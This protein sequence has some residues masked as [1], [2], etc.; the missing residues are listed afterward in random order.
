MQLPAPPQSPVNQFKLSLRREPIAAL[1][2]VST[3]KTEGLIPI[4]KDGDR[5]D[6][7]LPPP[8]PEAWELYQQRAR[9]HKV[10]NDIHLAGR[11]QK[12]SCHF[13]HSPLEPEAIYVM[14]Y[15]LSGFP[16]SKKG[17][18]RQATCYNGHICQRDGCSG[19]KPCKLNYS[20]HFLDPRVF[21]WLPPIDQPEP[22]NAAAAAGISEDSSDD[23]F[24]SRTPSLHGG[25]FI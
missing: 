5:I 25:A 13:D 3:T 20:M 23:P 2:P 19:G 7:F 11:C 14:K 8:K 12:P 1:L 24:M 10:C 6:V 17:K 18:C 16:C 15:I 9:I 4:N 21:E 22:G